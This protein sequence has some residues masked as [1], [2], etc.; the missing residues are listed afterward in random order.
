MS[1]AAATQVMSGDEGGFL[2]LMRHRNYALIWTGQLVSQTGDRMQWVAISLWVYSL[3]GSALSVSYAIMAL[4]IGPA[5]VGLYAG[6]VVD[7]LDRRRI[8][9]AADLIRGALVFAIP[10]LL[11][12]GIAWVYLALF[13]VSTASAFFRPA[14][15]AVIPLSVPKDRL[16]SANAFFASM[17]TSTEVY[18]PILA[19][20]LVAKYGYSAVIYLNAISYLVSAVFVSSLSVGRTDSSHKVLLKASRG[21]TM[22]M[23]REGLDYIRKDRLQM[24]LLA[25]VLGGHWVAGLSS[26][27]T[28]LARGVLAISE[29]QYGWYQ[30][31]W[32][33]GFVSASLLVGW[34][35]GGVPKGQAVLFGYAFWAVAAGM[36]GISTNYPMLVI[37]G[38]WVGFAN[39]LAFVNMSTI[40]MEHTPESGM[41]RLISTRQ[42]ALAFVRVTGLIG[43]GWLAD[44]TRNVRLAIVV[45]AFISF[46][47]TL[48]VALRFPVIWRYRARAVTDA[49]HVAPTGQE[50][51]PTLASSGFL[52]RHLEALIAPEYTIPEQHT[53]NKWTLLVL[54][55]AWLA[56]LARERL[57]AAGLALAIISIFLFRASYGALRR[58]LGR[59]L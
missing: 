16:L 15:Y 49:R 24:G 51:V 17:D 10:S 2:A 27:Q 48:V 25:V 38:F 56:L 58:S 4:L 1:T 30:S 34:Y 18:G 19:G 54:G 40:I 7:R 5:L 21:G 37:T 9:I 36:M 32:G 13:L 31:I 12:L 44:V 50:T 42:V 29:S 14:M 8:L 39:M 11:V 43:F 35:G 33:I 3:T 59:R 46:L 23:I 6:A 45:M 28:P 53:L 55:T 47:G 57:G 20:V 26:L 41:G 52:N 22:G